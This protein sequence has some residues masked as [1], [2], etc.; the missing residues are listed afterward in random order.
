MALP[1]DIN[2]DDYELVSHE[3]HVAE[4]VSTEPGDLP[5]PT[6]ADIAK[7]RR[8]SEALRRGRLGMAAVEAGDPDFAGEFTDESVLRALVSILHATRNYY[9]HK[10]LLERALE[11]Y[12]RSLGP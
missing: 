6:E 11:E 2:P 12:R 3:R 9:D 7:F 5:P 8:L 4:E 1:P 10:A